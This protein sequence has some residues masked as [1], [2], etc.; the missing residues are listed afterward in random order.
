MM[1][2]KL[3]FDVT[4]AYLRIVEKQILE[5]DNVIKIIEPTNPIF[6]DA[7]LLMTEV[8]LARKQIK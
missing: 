3:L 8:R 1:Y 6:N 4:M 2:N 5:C 7:S